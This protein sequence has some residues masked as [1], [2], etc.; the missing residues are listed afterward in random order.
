MIAFILSW[1]SLFLLFGAALGAGDVAFVRTFKVV[2][3]LCSYIH[4]VAGLREP[5]RRLVP[6]L[7][8]VPIV[9]GLGAPL[10]ASDPRA[11]WYFVA[12]SAI[13][14]V[15]SFITDLTGRWYARL[16]A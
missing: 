1:V 12:A 5:R 9:G 16:R 11:P 8:Y 3:I 13:L 2:L 7:W 15:V 4:F 14:A 10:W 6:C